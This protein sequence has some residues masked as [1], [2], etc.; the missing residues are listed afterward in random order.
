MGYKWAYDPKINEWDL[1]LYSPNGLTRRL[2]GFSREK[3]NW[4]LS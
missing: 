1:Y 4:G 3:P 2:I